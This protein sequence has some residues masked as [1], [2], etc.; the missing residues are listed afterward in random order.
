MQGVF[1]GERAN[2]YRPRPQVNIPHAITRNTWGEYYTQ[3]PDPSEIVRG[4]R[5][6]TSSS[7]TVRRA[8]EPIVYSVTRE[9]PTEYY[10]PLN[11][12][13][14]VHETVMQYWLAEE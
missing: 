12:Q 4:A 6:P 11:R 3:R 9:H 7:H 2:P 8:C 14:T 1:A 5:E 13:Q 10:G